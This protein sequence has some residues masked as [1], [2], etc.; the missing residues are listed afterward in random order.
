MKTNFINIFLITLL[1]ISYQQVNAQVDKL[2]EID[3]TYKDPI[4][5]LP[6]EIDYKYGKPMIPDEETALQYADII[7]K[8]RFRNIPFDDLKPYTINLIANERVWEIKV[9]IEN[10]K[11]KY[12]LIR[13]NKNNGEILNCWL[14]GK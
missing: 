4:K 1:V 9:H 10:Y 11:D 7:L 14:E 13:I 5:D 12:F 6:K 8:K 2:Q 3:D